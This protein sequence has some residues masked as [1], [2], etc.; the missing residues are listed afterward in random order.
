MFPTWQ[1]CQKHMISKQHTKLKYED[2]FWDEVDPFYD[3][4]QNADGR[5]ADRNS[6]DD[7]EEDGWED[8]SDGDDAEMDLADQA[9]S[10]DELY[11]AYEKE[12]ARFGLDVTPLGEL[13]FPDGRIVGHRALRKYYKQRAR[14]VASSTAIVAAKRAADERLYEGRVVNIGDPFN[15]Q[16][17]GSGRGILVPLKDGAKGFS[18]LS[19][20]RFRAVV[21]KQRRDDDMGHRLKL[22]TSRNINRMDKKANRLMNNVS[23]AHAKR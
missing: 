9:K 5:M 16:M 4:D 15:G 8:I 7:G 10:D 14:P 21:K 23:V 6:T 3:F 18:A 12:I 13:V 17:K 22:R 1:G 2:G 19:L 11:A 20:Y